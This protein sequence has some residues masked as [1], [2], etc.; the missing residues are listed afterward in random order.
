MKPPKWI[1]LSEYA[2]HVGCSSNV[3]V[4]AIEKGRIP[5]SA[6][7]KIPMPGVGGTN[8]RLLI[9]Q[10]EADPAWV[11]GFNEL[12]DNPTYP[13]RLAVERIRA[14]LDA[15]DSISNHSGDVDAE[16]NTQHP[17]V[18]Q[19]HYPNNDDSSRTS[20]AEAQ[21][22]EK[23]AKAALA[24]IELLQ[25]KESLVS[26]DAVYRQLFEAGQQL[27][28]SLM[29]IPNRITAEIISA[30]DNHAKVQQILTDAI[31]S[32]LESL[33]DFQNSKLDNR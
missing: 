24:Q 27:R 30:G 21:R 7:S 2:K 6:V 10:T 28:D 18:T 17:Q 12:S 5:D 13:A 8:Y 32:S 3:V 29:V 9:N 4:R 16:N 22:S 19:N 15:P 14:E 26:K 31:A 25:K 33:T 23:I 20:L 11:A 1:I